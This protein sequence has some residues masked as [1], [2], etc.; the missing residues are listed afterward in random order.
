M[1]RVTHGCCSVPDRDGHKATDPACQP[2]YHFATQRYKVLGMWISTSVPYLTP[3]SDRQGDAWGEEAARACHVGT[4]QLREVTQA[5]PPPDVAEALHL[6]AGTTAVVRR[7]RIDLD[8]TPVELADSWYP[9]A[10]A[11]WTP[12]AEDAK[13]KGGAVTLLAQLGYKANESLEDITFR[14]ATDEEAEA[15]SLPAATPVIVLFRTVL[16][17]DR[18]PFEVSVMTMVA[19][20]RHLRY[21]LVVG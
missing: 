18:T 5:V 13:I 14:A 1:A 9:H 19:E 11:D 4:Q 12:L 6:P 16:N 8:G 10:V 7:R 3:R 20:G 15:L 17:A 2:S 21:R